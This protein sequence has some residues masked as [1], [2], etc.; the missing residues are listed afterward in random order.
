MCRRDAR[1]T[2]IRDQL[3]GA[4]VSAARR[5]EQYDGKPE[6]D[7]SWE[8]TFQRSNVETLKRLSHTW[9]DPQPLGDLTP[10]FAKGLRGRL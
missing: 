5:T 10:Q 7:V 2:V 9:P 1:T 3:C 8:Q 4:A 6:G